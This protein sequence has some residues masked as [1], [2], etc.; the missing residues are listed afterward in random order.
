MSLGGRMT[1]YGEG[2]NSSLL[3][4]DMEMDEPVAWPGVEHWTYVT[5]WPTALTYLQWL[6]VIGVTDKLDKE[7]DNALPWHNHH[8]THLPLE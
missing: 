6:P 7:I 4:D 5:V 8:L 1:M 3:Q 2:G